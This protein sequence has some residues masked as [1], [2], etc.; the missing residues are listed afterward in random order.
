MG[1]TDKNI[2]EL[3]E[4]IDEIDDQISNL[5]AERMS[6]AQEIGDI[7]NGKGLDVV[8]PEREKIVFQKL[9]ERCARIGINDKLLKPI[10]EEIL[11][12]SHKIQNEVRK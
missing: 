1:Q 11:N 9:A 5:I 3:R 2:L 8:N 4:K 10:W 7:K 12:A 6:L